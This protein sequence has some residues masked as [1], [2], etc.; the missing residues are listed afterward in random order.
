MTTWI[1]D[2]RLEVRNTKFLAT[3][4]HFGHTDDEFVIVKPPAL[5]RRYLRLLEDERPE[6]IFELGIKDGGST[7]LLAL[8]ADPMLLLAA[9]LEA[10]MPPRLK[11]LVRS[12]GLDGRL[13]TAFG[14]DQSDRQA[15]TRFVDSHLVEASLD[16]VIDDASHI[17]APTRTS[18]EVLFPRLRPGGLFVIEDWSAECHTAAHLAR[19]LPDALDLGERVAAVSQMLHILNSP[20]HDLPEAVLTSLAQAATTTDGEHSEHNFALFE[21]LIEIAGRADLG[22]LADG[23]IGRSR[24]LADLA[25]EL[26]MISATNPGVIEEVR[27]DGEWLSARRGDADLP[28]D[29]FRLDDNWTDVFGY[30]GERD[31]S[32][33]R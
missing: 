26:M 11:E 18:F 27:I 25:V 15:L 1:S 12:Q 9:D 10:E 8:A 20:S 21:R 30:L 6:R 23:P 29:G 28:R 2:Q 32:G 31:R 19:V 13:V 22:A 5:V 17:L 7:A 14:L 16:L 24:P 33:P 3:A 4:V